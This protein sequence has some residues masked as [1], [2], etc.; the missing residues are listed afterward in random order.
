MEGNNLPSGNFMQET[1]RKPMQMRSLNSGNQGFNSQIPVLFPMPMNQVTDSDH[2]SELQFGERGKSDHHHHHQ[3]KDS[4]SDDEEHDLNEDATDGHIG[5]GKKGSAWQRMK[6][7][8]LMVKLLITAASYTGE[9]PGADLGGGRK[10]CAMMQKK[11]KWKA[12]S[13]VMGERGCNVSPQQCEDKFNDLN[14][15]YKRLTDILGRGTTCRVVANPALLDHMDNLSDKLKDDARKI[16][17][18]RHLFYEEMC[19]YH[20]NNRVSLPE[21]PALQRSLQLALR[22]K[23]ENDLKRGVSGDADEDDQTAESDSEEDN[24]EEHHPTHS[25]KGALPMHKRMRHMTDHE[26]VGFG[27]SSSSH[28]CSERTNL[29]GIALDINKVFLD[30]TSSALAQKDLALQLEQLEKYRFQIEIQELELA[31]QRFKWEQFCKK[32][33]RELERM[34]LESEQMRVENKRLALEVR[35]KELEFEL[36]VKGNDNH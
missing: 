9:D 13:K 32:K 15:R 2:L 29:H 20:N 25:S 30:G 16:L 17:S 26:D 1:V 7:T 34:E 33:D 3:T 27:N 23:E 31:E 14:K 12:I 6:W 22:C 4:M 11:G 36:K 24:D 10:S 18:S 21:D 19:S 35:R 28:D 5:K 8:D